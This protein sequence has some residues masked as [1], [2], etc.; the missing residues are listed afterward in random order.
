V[1]QFIAS[2]T[3]ENI[4]VLLVLVGMMQA[5]ISALHKVGSGKWLR[6]LAILA[7]CMLG[8]SQLV[9]ILY[10]LGA[11]DSPF[12]VE[13]QYFIRPHVHDWLWVFGL[14]LLLNAFYLAGVE[15][16][17]SRKALVLEHTQLLAE[18]AERRRAEGNLRSNEERFRTLIE[19]CTDLIAILDAEGKFL[20]VGAS[21]R[22]ILGHTADSMVGKSVLEFCHPDDVPLIESELYKISRNH[23]GAEQMTEVRVRHGDNS[24]RVMEAVGKNRLSDPVLNGIVVN[25]RDI[26]ERKLMAVRLE[27]V[28]AEEQQRIRHDLHDTVGQDLTGLLCMA[29]SLSRRLHDADATEGG[30]ARAEAIVE[31]VRHTI[32]DVRK[33][34]QGIAPVEADPRGLEVALGELVDKARAQ[35]EIDVRFECQAPI[36][37]IDYGA[38]TQL[39]R[40]AQE[41]LTN[42]VKHARAQR[43]D[44]SL[45]SE[46]Q[47]LELVIADDG[48]GIS[49]RKENSNGLGLHT[50]RSRAAAIGATLRISG[51]GGGGTR[52]E[53][54]LGRDLGIDATKEEGS[55][56]FEI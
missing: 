31:G 46:S 37:V 39:F 53:C 32:E 55:H 38:A 44:L 8:V 9:S 10:D 1:A 51:A 45:V 14:L 47:R 34:I 17:Q 29:G 11:L 23:L 54:V 42:A 22:Q 36:S 27:F 25:A 41:A 3:L 48:I 4:V 28:K 16:G 43:I 12:L 30:A 15:A 7:L 18:V 26:T 5:T 6:Q 50:M 19:N 21:V 2:E 20:Y 33:A 35:H 40:I 56:N 49:G 52:V 24:W 13:A